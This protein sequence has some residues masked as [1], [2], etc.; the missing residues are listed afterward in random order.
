MQILIR[1]SIYIYATLQAAPYCHLCYLRR[2]ID[3]SQA[4]LAGY[5]EKDEQSWCRFDRFLYAQHP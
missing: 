3:R 1:K 5:R 2:R 4:C